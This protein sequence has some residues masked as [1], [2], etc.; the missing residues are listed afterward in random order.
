MLQRPLIWDARKRCCMRRLCAAAARQLPRI[1]LKTQLYTVLTD[2]T[3][4][5]RELESLQQAGLCGP[6]MGRPSARLH[7]PGPHPL[8]LTRAPAA[9]PTPSPPPAMLTGGARR[10]AGERK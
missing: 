7:A 2:R 9:G 5:D 8:T 6:P 4:A 10:A 1:I 3:A